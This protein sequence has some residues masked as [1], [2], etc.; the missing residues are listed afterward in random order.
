METHHE[1]G[2]LLVQSFS[3]EAVEEHVR[4]ALML[5]ISKIQHF[6]KNIFLINMNSWASFDLKMYISI[7]HKTTRILSLCCM[8][9]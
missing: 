1:L 7:N 5:F 4:R 6:N 2:L 3:R 9:F 8:Y